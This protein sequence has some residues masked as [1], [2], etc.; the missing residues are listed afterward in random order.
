MSFLFEP[1]SIAG[2]E[3]TLAFGFPLADLVPR[4]SNTTTTATATFSDTRTVPVSHGKSLYATKT[5][6]W[7]SL[8]AWAVKTVKNFLVRPRTTAAVPRPAVDI[9]NR[10]DLAK[11]TTLSVYSPFWDIVKYK[12]RNYN[13]RPFH[14]LS[15]FHR[16]RRI[17]YGMPSPYLY[18]RL[19]LLSCLYGI[20]F[21]TCPS[22]FCSYN[23]LPPESDVHVQ[24]SR[25]LHIIQDSYNYAS[26]DTNRGTHLQ[27]RNNSALKINHCTGTYILIKVQNVVKVGVRSHRSP[28]PCESTII[29]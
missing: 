4:Q 13:T 20:T 3:D 7:Y 10:P 18:A 11:S 26:R 24:S 1:R 22:T 29:A 23:L 25:M 6:N 5:G 2:L 12:P 19:R 14:S 15:L 8:A 21:L 9:A 16:S 27:T 17:R 28:S